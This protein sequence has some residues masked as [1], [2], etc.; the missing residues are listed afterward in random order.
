MKLGDADG[1]SAEGY[2]LAATSPD[3]TQDPAKPVV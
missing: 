2:D 3:N 1:R